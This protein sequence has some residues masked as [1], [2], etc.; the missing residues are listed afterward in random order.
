M[1]HIPYIVHGIQ[2]FDHSLYIFLKFEYQKY[3]K[4]MSSTY[5]NHVPVCISNIYDIYKFYDLKL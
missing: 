4:K 3:I 5:I 2:Q 1:M